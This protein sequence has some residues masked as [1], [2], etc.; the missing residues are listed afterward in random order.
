MPVAGTQDDGDDARLATFMALHRAH[1]LDVVAVIGGEKVGAHQEQD[2]VRAVKVV[3]DLSVQVLAR[4]DSAVVPSRD[5]AVATEPGEV[6]LE[7]VAQRFVGVRI[8]EEHMGHGWWTSSRG[9]PVYRV[10]GRAGMR[11]AVTA[12]GTG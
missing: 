9:S 11:L 3:V 6:L 4:A 8:G 7:L 1:H 2:D 10:I 12:S 5:N